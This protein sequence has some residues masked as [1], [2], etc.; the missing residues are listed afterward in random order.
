MTSPISNIANTRPAIAW[1]VS[2]LPLLDPWSR[3]GGGAAG[4]A[5]E[6]PFRPPLAAAPGIAQGFAV[7]PSQ[8][9]PYADADLRGWIEDRL[10]LELGVRLM[11]PTSQAAALGDHIGAVR[12]AILQLDGAAAHAEAMRVL[13]DAV[14]S[15]EALQ[16]GRHALKGV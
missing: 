2:R 12:T 9:G 6:A 16:Q 8:V 15:H 1:L 11:S 13:K 14:A 4:G 7:G 3:M 10:L 5:G